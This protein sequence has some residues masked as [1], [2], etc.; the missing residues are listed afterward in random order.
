VLERRLMRCRLEP[1]ST[2]L[3]AI[4][5]AA[6]LLHCGGKAA[7]RDD[8]GSPEVN[9]GAKGGTGGS[10]NQAGSGGSA[11]GG[12]AGTSTEPYDSGFET[13]DGITHRTE[14]K[15]CQNLLPRVVDWT[16]RTGDSCQSD[17]D[18]TEKPYGHCDLFNV[19]VTY[20][21]C[22]YGCTEDADCAVD[23]ICVC[24]PSIGTCQRSNCRTDADCGQGF[25]CASYRS[26]D[27]VGA[28]FACQT[29]ADECV[30]QAD[31]GGTRCD[32]ESDGVRRCAELGCPPAGR[33]FLIAEEVRVA[34]PAARDDWR[35]GSLESASA[36][37]TEAER[38]ALANA[39]LA[40]ALME[41]ASIAAFARF[42]LELLAVG[43]PA[44]LVRDS[45]TAAS[46]E[47]RHAEQ[48]FTLASHCAG[49][50]LGPGALAVDG[51]LDGVSLEKLVVTA[52]AEGCVGET[53]AAIEAAEQL[54]HATDAAVREVLAGIS[55]DET[56]HAELAW[57]FV[58]WALTRE[59]SLRRV[60]AREFERHLSAPRRVAQEGELDLTRH[61]IL[62]GRARS[63]L[64]IA[65]L[66]GVVR[67]CASA[68]LAGGGGSAGG[69]RD[70]TSLER[71][72]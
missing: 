33:P 27:C 1:W 26:S 57:R 29:S 37:L 2:R 16:S 67:N 32:L 38:Q 5:A 46:D 58:A 30:V 3:L 61:G 39:W 28:G 66:D 19:Q 69:V 63:E 44:D 42:T 12:N 53:V 6:P 40:N 9:A 23:Q 35:G 17:E 41:H 8:D 7:E 45:I 48:C 11:S 47:T 34:P 52:I 36:V 50:A 62:S 56:R 21:T 59:P 72:A 20:R 13:S 71:T 31:C 70:G 51:A 65:V 43:A 4:L 18:C 15:A 55:E 22:H 68:L 24:G 25:W 49:E 14:A 54:A 10:L 64:Q 60:A